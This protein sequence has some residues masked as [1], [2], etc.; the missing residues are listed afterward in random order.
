MPKPIY[1]DLTA[2]DSLWMATATNLEECPELNENIETEVAIIGAGFTGCSA[3]LHLRENNIDVTVIDA[4]QPG[5]GASGRNGGQV[6]PGIKRTLQEVQQTWG[7]DLG[8]TLYNTIGTAPG[9][10]IWAH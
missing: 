3:A 2:P 6:N 9:F 5:I 1:P 7:T 4:G 8:K 10:R